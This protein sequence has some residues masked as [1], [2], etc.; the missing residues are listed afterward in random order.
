MFIAMI[1]LFNMISVISEFLLNVAI[2]II[3][4]NLMNQSNCI[5]FCV[6]VDYPL[7]TTKQ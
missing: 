7:T 6:P 3:C 5:T 2:S 1:M 4:K